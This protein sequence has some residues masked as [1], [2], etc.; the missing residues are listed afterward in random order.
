MT[1]INVGIQKVELTDQHLR[2]EQREIKRITN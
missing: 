2:A 1:R